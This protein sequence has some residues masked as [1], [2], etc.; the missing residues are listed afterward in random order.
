M[1]QPSPQ[2]VQRP[3][4][5]DPS[6]PS[7]QRFASARAYLLDVP[8]PPPPKVRGTLGLDLWP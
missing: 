1:T 7:A 4:T 3:V 5:F 8:S 6:D 2:P